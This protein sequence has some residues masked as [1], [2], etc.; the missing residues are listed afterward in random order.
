MGTLKRWWWIP[1]VALIGIFLK[2]LLLTPWVS[3]KAETASIDALQANNIAAVDFV[4]VDGVSGLGGDGLNV[5][6]E[7][8]AADEAAAV[9]AV[10]ARDEVNN[11]IYRPTDD[12]AAAVV[13]EPEPDPEPEETQAPAA[14]EL[15]APALGLAASG[16]AIVLSGTVANELTRDAVVA[17]AEAQ[18]GAANVT[19]ELTIDA[20]TATEGGAITVTGEATSEVEQADWVA[21]ATAVASTGGLDVIDRTTVRAVEDQL[22]DLFE[23]EPIEFDV[24]RSTIRSDSIPTLDAA[25]AAITANPGAGN[26]QVVGH[27]DGDGMAAANQRLSEA[28][29]TAVLAY[30]TETGGVD[31]GRLEAVGLGETELLVD[32]ELTP[33]D[34]QRNRRIEWRR[35]P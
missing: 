21:S 25:A 18:Y 4:E 27:T 35:L 23:L 12:G 30:L 28:R 2:A 22:N 6:L 14:P 10:E 3:G 16:G 7:G 32:P 29:A 19:D 5:V 17:E 33:E 1:L 13:A 8:P 11:V 15:R 20:E 31:P 24:N 9:A 26:F 34:K